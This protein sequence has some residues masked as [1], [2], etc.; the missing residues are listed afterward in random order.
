MHH[1]I[2]QHSHSG[3]LTKNI[4]KNLDLQFRKKEI[5]RKLEHPGSRHIGEDPLESFV[6]GVVLLG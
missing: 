6:M 1:T 3:R 2:Y 5:E 4:Y